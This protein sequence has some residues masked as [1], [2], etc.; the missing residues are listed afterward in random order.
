[1]NLFEQEMTRQD[2]AATQAPAKS[3]LKALE[4]VDLSS[5]NFL[6]FT[7]SKAGPSRLS[8]FT[9][10]ITFSERSSYQPVLL[11]SI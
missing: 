8:D 4:H 1:M 7:L 10:I 2:Q 6:F 11:F 9:L 3:H 5:W